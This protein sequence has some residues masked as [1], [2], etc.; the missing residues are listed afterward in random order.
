MTLMA[1]PYR[2]RLPLLLLALGVGLNSPFSAGAT[3]DPSALTVT[4]QLSADGT[5]LHGEAAFTLLHSS[6]EPLT[7]L[8]LWLYPNRFRQDWRHLPDPLVN[9]L[10]P[11]GVDPTGMTITR[12]T[13]NGH[14]LG[15]DALRTLP[16]S[17]PADRRVDADSLLEI[18]LPTA[19]QSGEPLQLTIQ[20]VVLIPQRRGRFGRHQDTI[21]LAGGFHPLLLGGERYDDLRRHP[22]SLPTTLRI[23]QPAHRGIVAADQVFPPVDTA[24]VI[25]V[26]SEDFDIP[27]V[28]TG[29]MTVRTDTVEG[30]SLKYVTDRHI[31]VSPG[32][33]HSG[34]PTRMRHG[35][36]S[37][38][39]DAARIEPSQRA[40][41]IAGEMV[42]Q[43]RQAGGTL[44][45]Q[46][47]LVEIPAFDQLTQLSADTVLLSNH[48]WRTAPLKKAR[49]F[50]D[51]HLAKT[52]ATA[53]ARHHAATTE[54]PH[55]PYRYLAPEIA[56][57]T[58]TRQWLR[59]D[60]SEP[61]SLHQ[62]VRFV[63]FIPYVDS[64]IYAPQ[65][66]FESVYSASVEE[67]EPLRDAL[68]R[69][70]NA[71]PRGR[72][73]Y[74]KLVDRLSE[75]AVDNVIL[76]WIR[77]TEPFTDHLIRILGVQATDRFQRDFQ[78]VYP[79]VQHG[80]RRV[81]RLKSDDGT[82]RVLVDVETRGDPVD[83]PV[84]LRLRWRDGRVEDIRLERQATPITVER[85]GSVPLRSV[86]IDPDRRFLETA[87]SPM[88]PHPLRD[89]R[90]PPKVRPPLL[91]QLLIWGDSVTR[92]PF[93]LASTSLRRQYD[94]DHSFI[95][96]GRHT[97]RVSGGSIGWIHHLGAALTPNRRNAYVGPRLSLH[98]HRPADA[99][100][101][102][103]PHRNRFSATLISLDMMAGRDNRRFGMDP[104]KGHGISVRLGYAQGLT[105]DT[106]GRHGTLSVRGGRTFAPTPGHRVAVYGGAEGKVGTPPAS[107]LSSLSHRHA[108]RG[109]DLDETYGQVS[110]YGVT[111]YRRTLL[112]SSNISMPL[113]STVDRL[114]GVL[115][116]GGGSASLPGTYRHLF[117]PDRQFVEVGCGL[118]LFLLTL[119]VVPYLIAVDVAV[120]ILPRNRTRDVWQPGERLAT[121]TRS[122]FRFVMGITQTF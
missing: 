5:T 26:H 75:D 79:R 45:E 81:R 100:E 15:A 120:P 29:P 83:H 40:L 30:V 98:H 13:V 93:L 43:F 17:R 53:L 33:G 18:Q 8:T 109:F 27:L 62:L 116:L 21:S 14:P 39:E 4:I 121:I 9:W 65:I 11:R 118:R 94:I 95:L 113:G 46:L 23:T 16:F 89:N 32:S 28:I 59:S 48:I 72:R 25:E 110:L 88:D 47:T 10:Y 91:D 71:L 78:D 20:Y 119:G 107:G 50:H 36:P 57:E 6:P 3:V 56:A 66:P 60:L 117:R 44:P 52:V 63:S 85:T 92:R 84:T 19:V 82:H 69:F 24:R 70:N 103:I 115:F 105:P 64:L 90:W 49:S 97:P 74:S 55:H 77:G 22:T 80:I 101:S 114:Q 73:V 111:E 86:E 68:W 106:P 51:Q 12:L 122:P 37:A 58:L 7:Q 54:P 87:L 41:H 35:I 42:R 99:A 2:L 96:E 67:P 102:G 34:P 104:G 38:L 1:T 61:V 76:E 112:G 108:L 31:P